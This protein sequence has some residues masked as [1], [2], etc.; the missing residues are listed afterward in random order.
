MYIKNI[1]HQKALLLK[2]EI[3]VEKGQIISKT[4]AQNPYVSVTLFAFS[5]GEAIGEHDS[6][7]DAMVLVLEGTGKY[8]VGGK[9]YLVSEGETLV[10]PAKIPHSVFA[11]EDFKMLLTVV[12]PQDK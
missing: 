1:E 2:D 6:N 3:R 11:E 9:E 5:K 8:V 4:L 12:F 7:G 10:M